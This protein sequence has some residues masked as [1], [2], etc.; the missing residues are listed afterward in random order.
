MTKCFQTAIF[1]ADTQIWSENTFP[2]KITTAIR[3]QFLTKSFMGFDIK[4]E[5]NIMIFSTLLVKAICNLKKKNN[6]IKNL[7][8]SFPLL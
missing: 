7:M 1:I 6:I 3:L 8:L 2:V 4:I 5:E